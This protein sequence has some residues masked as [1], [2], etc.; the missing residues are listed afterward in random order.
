[1]NQI[2]L[3][4]E[5]TEKIPIIQANGGQL[6]QVFTNLIINAMHASK[7]DSVIKI[8]TG[9]SPSVG[10]F[11]GTVEIK[12]IDQGIGIPDEIVNKIFEPFFTTKDVGK[13][14]GLGLSLSYGIIRDHGGEIRVDSEV[15][16]GSTFTIILPIQKAFVETDTSIK[17][18][19]T[20]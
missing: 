18:I 11:G 20:S 17:K 19:H 15:G 4:V 2:T 5:T 10:E 12:V 6:Q 14:T 13:G 1:M 16:I 7:P 3:E 8:T 9:F